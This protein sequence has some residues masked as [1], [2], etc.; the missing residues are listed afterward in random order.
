PRPGF[1]LP[2]QDFRHEEFELERRRPGSGGHKPGR[3][4]RCCPAIAVDLGGRR[5]RHR[6]RASAVPQVLE[7]VDHRL[8]S[9]RG[10]PPG[11]MGG[12]RGPSPGRGGK[13][14]PGCAGGGNNLLSPSRISFSSRLPL[15]SM[16]H[17]LNN[18]SATPSNCSWVIFSSCFTPAT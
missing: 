9:S 10:W 4:P 1:H 7:T 2:G 6:I 8:S 11:G 15:L 12:K 18:F 13:P 5:R 3:Q 17:S 16:S 14:K